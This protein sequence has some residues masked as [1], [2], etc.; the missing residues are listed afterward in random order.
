[1]RSS[2]GRRDLGINSIIENP[3]IGYTNYTSVPFPSGDYQK[4]IFDR[5]CNGG[6]SHLYINNVENGTL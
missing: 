3:Y 5:I 2:F 6:I 4:V 1:M